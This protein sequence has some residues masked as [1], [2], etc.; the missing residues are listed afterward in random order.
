VRAFL[1]ACEIDRNLSRLTIRQYELY[2]DHLQGWLSRR[3]PQVQDLGDI[4]PDVVR[5]AGPIDS[6][7]GLLL[8][9]SADGAPRGALIWPHTA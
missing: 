4:D 9:R 7:I 6:E 2:L 5:A 3:Q 1:E 8:V